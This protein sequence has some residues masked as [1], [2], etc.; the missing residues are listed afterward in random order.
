[1]KQQAPLMATLAVA[2]LLTACGRPRDEDDPISN[3]RTDGTVA[4]AKDVQMPAS[5]AAEATAR[6]SG[7]MAITA[8]V[9]AAL[10]ADDQLKATQINVD[11]RE[12]QVTLTGKAPDAQARD[13]AATLASAVDG[14]RQ[15]NNQLVVHASG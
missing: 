15:V 3:P 11:T 8:K 14:V 2:T 7:D 6:I 13:R 4:A 1:M 10:V 12:G 9:N 5:R